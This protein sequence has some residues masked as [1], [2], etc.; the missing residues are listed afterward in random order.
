MPM[1]LLEIGK[2]KTVHTLFVNIQK[3]SLSPINIVASDN[4][5]RQTI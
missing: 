1:E 4:E 2:S 5:T 3:V